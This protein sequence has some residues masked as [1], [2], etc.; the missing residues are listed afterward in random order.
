[1][2]ETDVFSEVDLEQIDYEIF[3]Q[4]PHTSGDDFPVLSCISPR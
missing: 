1:M 3:D 4:L 2:T